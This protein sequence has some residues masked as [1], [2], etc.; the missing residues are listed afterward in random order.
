M[1]ASASLLDLRTTNLAISLARRSATALKCP[2]LARIV[3][4]TVAKENPKLADALDVLRAV[5]DDEDATASD[6]KRAADA[7]RLLSED[8]DPEEEKD[9]K[10]DD[11]KPLSPEEKEALDRLAH[12]AEG[13]RPLGRAEQKLFDQGNRFTQNDPGSAA[14]TR[15]QGGLRMPSRIL[16]PEESE[17]RV[18]ELDRQWVGR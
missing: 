16:T 18:A 5:R 6:R 2:A 10:K 15:D 3:K 9:G 14:A 12:R 13:F 17:A 4:A 7:L 11:K 8:E 1:T